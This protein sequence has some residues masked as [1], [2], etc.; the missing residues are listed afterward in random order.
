MKPFFFCNRLLLFRMTEVGTPEF[1]CP[2]QITFSYSP[3]MA[4]HRPQNCLPAPDPV[5]TGGL[6]TSAEI[7]WGRK[8]QA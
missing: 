2:I 6:Q 3:H 5:F 7:T 8:L 1:G 4:G